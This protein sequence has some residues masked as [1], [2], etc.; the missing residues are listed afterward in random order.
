MKSVLSY[1]F[2]ELI[3]W[4]YTY[5]ISICRVVDYSCNKVFPSVSF[6]LYL[7]FCCLT[8]RSQSQRNSFP[9]ELS[10]I[11]RQGIQDPVGFPSFLMARSNDWGQK[12]TAS[13]LVLADYW[14]SICHWILCLIPQHLIIHVHCW[15]E[16]A[17]WTS[18]CMKGVV[19]NIHQSGFK[20]S[21]PTWLWW[22]IVVCPL[23]YRP[24]HAF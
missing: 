10:S 15:A 5:F 14:V 9:D 8:V 7:D 24:S 18:S 13:G 11:W 3:K 1:C 2:G 22:Q 23:F 12:V 6:C 16:R 19:M 21:L 17:N 4:R 20:K